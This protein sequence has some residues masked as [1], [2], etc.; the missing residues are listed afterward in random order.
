VGKDLRNWLNTCGLG[1]V[2]RVGVFGLCANDPRRHQDAPEPLEFWRATSDTALSYPPPQHVLAAARAWPLDPLGHPSD[3]FYSNSAAAQIAETMRSFQ[4]DI[5]IVEGLWLYHYI[6]LVKQFPC[7]VV[8]DCH[9][10][11]AAVFQ[12]IADIMSGDEPATRLIRKLLPDRTQIIE[13]R[14]VQAVDQIWVCSE[15]DARSMKDLYGPATPVHVVPNGVDLA[16]YET[17]R[18]RGYERPKTVHPSGRV[19]IFPA[20]FGYAPNRVAAS[21]LIKEFFP[22]LAYE[23]P[24]CQ[25]LLAG[26]RPSPEMLAATR[27]EP[28][29]VV[30]G[31]VPDMRP[32]L[33]A[34]ASTI[35]PLFHGSGTRFKLL[36]SFAAGVPVISTAKGAEGLGVEDG[37]DLLLAETADELIEAVK[38][39]WTDHSLA[40]ELAA[41][42]LDLV[43]RSYS[44]PAVS[45]AI[46]R[47]VDELG[48][49]AYSLTA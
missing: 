40:Q 47:A 22:R 15:N 33:A 16:S 39:L 43:R 10:V 2:S 34:A 26:D 36:E 8:L 48:V 1:S 45:R 42:G 44:L 24:D 6:D 20:L 21:F 46:V 12:Q 49:A 35:V 4:P 7:R 5:V 23:F 27:S 28:R 25:L 38:R 9:N 11:E 32:Y 19:L 30:T 3:V 13:Q 37:K 31:G 41:N 29:I 17:A 18:S 14:A